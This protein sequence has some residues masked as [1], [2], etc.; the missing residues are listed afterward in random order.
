MQP[1]LFS[2]LPILALAASVVASPALDAFPRSTGSEST[3]AAAKVGPLGLYNAV[4]KDI[5]L[6]LSIKSDNVVVKD[7]DDNY[8][9]QTYVSDVILQLSARQ[10]EFAAAHLPGTTTPFSGTFDI[11]AKYCQPLRGAKAGSSLIVG[12][13]GIGFDSSYWD[14]AWKPEYSFVKQAASYG[15]STLIY[16]RLGTGKSEAPSKGGFSV[17]QAPTEVAILREILTQI[18]QDRLPGLPKQRYTRTVLLGH[19]YGSAQTAD[20]AKNAPELV[21]AVVLTG[22]TTFGG[23]VANF[24]QAGAYTISKQVYDLLHL[25]FKPSIYI[26]TGSP[27]SDLLSFF[28]PFAYDEGAFELARKT[29]A[30]TTLGAFVSISAIGG[31]AD[32]FTGPVLVV[33]GDRD[34]PFCGT[35][36]SSTTP[37]IPDGV[38]SLYPAASSFKSVILPNTGHGIVAHRTG[39]QQS[40][41]ILQ[42]LASQGL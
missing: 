7:L 35:D 8:S 2:L 22:F 42:W 37:P 40:E 1:S 13:H 28:Q 39:P 23:Y 9:N 30:P 24:F 3:L 32:R 15:Y 26:S 33:N 6:T 19:S 18:R 20:I 17:V 38:K 5:Q 12:V 41:E 11:A 36:C 34:F 21:D 27:T 31:V 4:C 29:Q 25:R 16:D 14:F 10:A